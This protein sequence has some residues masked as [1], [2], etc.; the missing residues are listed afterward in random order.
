MTRREAVLSAGFVFLVALAVRWYAATLVVFP[1]PEDTAYYVDV[2]RN[3]LA[4][5]GLVTDALWS[6]GT[7]PLV[8]PRDAFEVWLPFPTFAAAVPMALLGATFAAAQVSS[9]LIGAL[10]P[11]LAWRLGA[12]VSAERGLPPGRAR[13]LAIGTG[14]TAAVSLPLILH[15]TLPDST[16]PFAAL[17]LAACLLITRIQSAARAGSGRRPLG[18]L[19]GLG[20]V[21]GLAALTR[22]EA[23][24]LALAWAIVA[25]R[26]SL[27]A[28][29]RLI[30]IAI[31]AAVALALFAP[32]M[33]RNWLAFGSPLP[34]QALTNALSVQGTDIFAWSEP[35]T[36]SRYLAVGPA[37]LLEMRVVGIEHNLFDV[38][39]VPGAPLSVIGLL[40]L[41]LL[42]RI[43]TLQPLML[44]SILIFL[45]T[46]LVFPV[47]TTWGTFLHAAGAA[48]V[49][50]MISALLALDRL[51]AAIGRRRGWTR[52][53]AWL[54]P[55]LAVAGALLFSTVF[56][57][58]FG[59]G[60]L[61]TARQFAAL[62]RQ[63]T[64]AGLPIA[65]LG[66]VI[67]DAPIWVPYVG[68]GEGL[69]LPFESPTS[70]MDLAR[71]FGARTVVVVDGA[72]PFPARIAAGEPDSACFEPVAI[73]PPVDPADAAAFA[74]TRVYRIVCP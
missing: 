52:P 11:V 74:E 8:V 59:S 40:A 55:A 37:R 16:M 4:G 57:P 3:L 10:V 51:I 31:P 49:L 53:V 61:A 22:N 70:V 69:A 23:A 17:V 42:A 6:F 35:V 1:K 54:A 45:V 26:L 33:V 29:D 48:H 27:P 30:L 5:R 2:A 62:D 66:P 34:G 73:G 36:V 19:V 63:M 24:W 68:G 50:L 18:L 58:A 9:V 28:R 60:S 47:S 56:M 44:V 38:L 67:T 7:D 12:D 41:P 71:H 13:T 46:S 32:W 25:W 64:A 43:R 65:D 14:L 20:V 72:H 39:L 15:S 21:L